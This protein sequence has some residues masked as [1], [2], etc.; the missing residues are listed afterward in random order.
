M[1]DVAIELLRDVFERRD[2]LR[3][4]GAASRRFLEHADAKAERGQLLAELIVHLAR[5]TA[6][7]VFLGK[8]QSA[9][10]LCARAFAAFPLAG[11]LCLLPLGQIEMRADDPYDWA[12]RLAAHRESTRQYVDVVA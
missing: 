9:E 7:F 4:I 1:I 6:P 11:L 12:V 5:D 3:Q 2:L 10:E 8:H